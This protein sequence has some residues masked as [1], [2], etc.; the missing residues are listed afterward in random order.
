MS[1]K[2]R[3]KKPRKYKVLL[4]NIGNTTVV[5]KG[6]MILECDEISFSPIDNFDGELEI[7]YNPLD[8]YS[9]GRIYEKIKKIN[10]S[11]RKQE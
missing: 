7:E 10:P 4:D 9:I 3:D 2:A 11:R 6:A 1:K 8:W 5:G